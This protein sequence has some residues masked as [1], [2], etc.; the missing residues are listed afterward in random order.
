MGSAHPFDQIDETD[1]RRWLGVE[2]F[3]RAPG[4]VAEALVLETLAR[5]RS[6][7]NPRP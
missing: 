3:H 5:P 2:H 1:A 6:G 4:N 7:S